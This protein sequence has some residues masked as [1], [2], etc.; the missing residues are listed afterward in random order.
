MTIKELQIIMERANK[1]AEE[2]YSKQLEKERRRENNEARK[3]L[4]R[5][6]NEVYELNK[7]V[8]FYGIAGMEYKEFLE[9]MKGYSFEERMRT[10]FA[11]YKH[12][13]ALDNIVFDEEGE[14]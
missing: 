7:E 6:R 11:F 9:A 13:A 8:G 12:I 5:I 10:S 2:F 4:D 3:E 1:E 14:A